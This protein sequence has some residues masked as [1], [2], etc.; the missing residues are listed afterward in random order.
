MIVQNLVLQ[1]NKPLVLTLFIKEKIHCIIQNSTTWLVIVKIKPPHSIVP[2]NIPI[3]Y[4]SYWFIEIEKHEKKNVILHVH[5]K[6]VR[7]M[8]A[9]C[10]HFIIYFN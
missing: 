4:K 2:W 10:I 5:D 9:Q 7:S 1:L 6:C 3:L 8:E